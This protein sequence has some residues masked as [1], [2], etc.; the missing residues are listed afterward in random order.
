[1]FAFGQRLRTVNFGGEQLRRV[2]SL[3]KGPVMLLRCYFFRVFLFEKQM[4][5]I[6]SCYINAELRFQCKD[7]DPIV[8]TGLQC[9]QMQVDDDVF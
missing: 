6:M 9:N 2:R 3:I 4:S 5:Q 7:L 8:N 1:M